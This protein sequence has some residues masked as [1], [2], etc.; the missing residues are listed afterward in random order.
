MDE[1][2]QCLLMV[3]YIYDLLPV[4]I[5]K[6]LA[7][8]CVALWGINSSFSILLFIIINGYIGYPICL[9]TSGKVI[10]YCNYINMDIF[11]ILAILQR[12]VWIEQNWINLLWNNKK[13]M[14]LFSRFSES[15]GHTY[16]AT[17]PRICLA[18]EVNHFLNNIPFTSD[19][20]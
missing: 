1:L 18:N 6:L 13:L 4:T 3:Q 7:R 9:R 20:R 14:F 8:N 17:R 5:W 2:L 19:R 16:R 12:L 10:T 11:C 15:G